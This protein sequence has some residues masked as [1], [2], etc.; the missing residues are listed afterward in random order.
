[1]TVKGPAEIPRLDRQSAGKGAE[2]LGVRAMADVCKLDG[3]K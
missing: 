2:T 1:M 3:V